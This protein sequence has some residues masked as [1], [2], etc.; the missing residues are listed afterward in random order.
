M[1]KSLKLLAGLKIDQEQ[2][3]N[4]G[5]ELPTDLVNQIFNIRLEKKKRQLMLQKLKNLKIKKIQF[6]IRMRKFLRPKP[7]KAYRKPIVSLFSSFLDI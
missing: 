7:K 1:V 6:P 4:L 2:L 3:L 5:L